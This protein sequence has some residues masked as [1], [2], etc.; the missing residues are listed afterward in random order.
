MKDRTA[1]L[2][3][4][5]FYL[6]LL[7]LSL[8]ASSLWREVLWGL[9]A[10]GFVSFAVGTIMAIL[11]AYLYSRRLSGPYDG[12]NL[13]EFHKIPDSGKPQETPTSTSKQDRI[14][15]LVRMLLVLIVSIIALWLLRARHDFW[16]ERHALAAAIDAGLFARPGAPFAMLLHW[17]LF[18][19]VNVTFLAN[20]SNTTV[21][22]SIIAG[23]LYILALT[24]CVRLLFPDANERFMRT[25]SMILLTSNG[26]VVL[27]FGAGGTTP[28]AAAMALFFVL[29]SIMWIRKEAPIILPAVLLVLALLA[30]LSTVYLVPGFIFMI[31]LAIRSHDRRSE[32]LKAV[33]ILAVGWLIIEFILLI[34]GG[35]ISPA[36]HLINSFA[37]LFG[38]PARLVG[39]DLGADLLAGLN[40]LLFL[41]PVSVASLVLLV[42][43]RRGERHEET[44]LFIF[45]VAALVLFIL[46]APRIDGGLRW[47]ILAAT[48]PSLSLYTL[49]TLKHRLT[50]RKA[51]CRAV[52]LLAVIGIFHSFPILY[53]NLVPEAASR[54]LISLPLD[55]GRAE[56][57]LGSRAFEGENLE[58]AREWFL[59]TVEKDSLNAYAFFS[60]GRIEL[61]QDRKIEAIELFSRSLAL[62]PEKTEYRLWLAEAYIAHRWFPEAIY[63]LEHLTN[64]SPGE[65]HY[66]KRLG[67]AR[68]H[69]GFYLE[70]IEAYE[71]AL[72][73]EPDDKQNVRNLVSA[74]LNRGAQLQK[75]GDT[76]GAKVHYQRA[77]VLYPNDWRAYN[78]LAVIETAAGNYEA[79][80]E[81]LK[82]GLDISPYISKLNTNMGIVLENLGRYREA[83]EYLRRSVQFDQ[84]GSGAYEAIE[85]IEKKLKEQGTDETE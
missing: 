62:T 26:F 48:G 58:K 25:R 38:G 46:G 42:G 51:L 50:E 74:V 54:R 73:L 12:R 34:W 59:T 80:F 44:L 23:A 65:V 72:E 84:Y 28:V 7:V 40:C 49:W 41:G 9:H 35:G 11:V 29:S 52:T 13:K 66:W 71:K 47:D 4:S 37:G 79:A 39:G 64:T 55:P 30:H 21:V 15:D 70:A 76:E 1:L 8:L 81:I 18:R 43:G 5:I 24:R 3:I 69:G 31:I 10:W 20:G 19:I 27:F 77:I 68:N 2:P 61:K 36:R 60:L 53:L 6:A 56:M 17:I 45:A 16:G 32:A 63:E 67:F 33:G 22:M 75:G 83:L 85:R 14:P 78:N 57:I 82:L